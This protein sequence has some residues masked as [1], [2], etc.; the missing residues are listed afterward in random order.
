[1]KRPSGFR[2]LEPLRLRDD[3]FK[4]S[5]I[6]V[7][8]VWGRSK[9]GPVVV[10]AVFGVP[11]GVS[12]TGSYLAELSRICGETSFEGK[13]S[14]FSL[15]GSAVCASFSFSDPEST[16]VGSAFGAGSIGT[17]TSIGV[18][19]IDGSRWRA[20]PPGVIIDF[21]VSACLRWRALFFMYDPRPPGEMADS[22]I[23][24]T[25][26]AFVGVLSSD[27]RPGNLNWAGF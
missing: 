16:G 11:F 5:S 18:S 3:S 22:A 23:G 19:P 10:K 14:C 12:F 27:L 15:P 4:A 8:G 20:N 25:P 6:V 1:M 24:V 9:P 17:S 13:G 26:G 7:G 2:S 21:D